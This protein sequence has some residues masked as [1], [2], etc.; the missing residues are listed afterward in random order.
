MNTFTY[1]QNNTKTPR[2][3]NQPILKR[4]TNYGLFS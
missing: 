3:E 4:G 1:L 2:E